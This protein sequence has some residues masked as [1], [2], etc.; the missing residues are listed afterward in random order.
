MR[1]CVC[2]AVREKAPWAGR[3]EVEMLVPLL[4]SMTSET[5]SGP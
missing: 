2:T 4:P 5:L 3:G 1:G